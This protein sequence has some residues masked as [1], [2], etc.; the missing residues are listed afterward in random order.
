MGSIKIIPDE[1]RKFITFEGG[2][3]AGKSTQIK[4]LSKFLKAEGLST[5]L[6]REPGGSNGGE[7]IRRLLVEGA[8]DRWDPMAETLLHMAA[9]RSHLVDL[10]EPALK[11]GKWVLCDR[12]ADSTEAYQGYGQGLNLGFVSELRRNI[13]GEIEPE[14]TFLLDISV[15]EGLARAMAR[16]NVARYEQMDRSIHEK[17]RLGFLKI[18]AENERR[19]VVIDASQSMNAIEAEIRQ[20]TVQRF[21]LN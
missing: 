8:I 1:L 16:G 2:E 15:N 3:G 14:L 11:R 12:F 20:N 5:K 10:I 21:G 7:D 9:R 19:V 4:L 6:T 18:A 17:I 13:L